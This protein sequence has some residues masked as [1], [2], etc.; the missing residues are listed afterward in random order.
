MALLSLERLTVQPA[1]I[2]N[3]ATPLYIEK[4]HGWKELLDSAC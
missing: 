2:L 4:N 1:K 3:L